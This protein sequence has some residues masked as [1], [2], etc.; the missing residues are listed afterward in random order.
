MTRPL[1]Q[2]AT[3]NPLGYRDLEPQL[4]RSRAIDVRMIDVREP[5]EFT[6]EL[7]HI[8]GAELVPLATV[9]TAAAAWDRQADLLIVCRSGGRSGRAAQQ[10][11]ALGFRR[12][13]NLAGGM[14]A[15]NQAGLPNACPR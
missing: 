9:A 15:Y 12:V 10:L 2:S 1:Y 3:E 8:P 4:L 6:G 7:G 5:H 13:M 14:L 11:V